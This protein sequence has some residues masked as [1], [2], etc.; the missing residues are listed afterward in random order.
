[1]RGDVIDYPHPPVCAAKKGRYDWSPQ[2][3]ASILCGRARTA[4]FREL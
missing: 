4:A 3:E 1:M 2:D